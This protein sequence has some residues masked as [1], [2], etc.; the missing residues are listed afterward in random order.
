MKSGK[1]TSEAELNGG[2]RSVQR[3]VRAARRWLWLIGWL[4]VACIAFVMASVGMVLLLILEAWAWLSRKEQGGLDE[5]EVFKHAE[6]L[7][8]PGMYLWEWWMKL[9]RPNVRDHRCSPEASAT[10]TERK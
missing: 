6:T 7:C 1:E 3:L 4:P 9:V 10:N 8:F 5:N 2:S